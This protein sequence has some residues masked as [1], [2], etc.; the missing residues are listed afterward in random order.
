MISGHGTGATH[1]SLQ[2]EWG[3]AFFGELTITATTTEE[4]GERMVGLKQTKRAV[5][6][7]TCTA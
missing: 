3:F 7:D 6:A 1:C 5:S 2:G 4:K